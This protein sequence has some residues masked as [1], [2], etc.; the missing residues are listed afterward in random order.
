[1]SEMEEETERKEGKS[2]TGEESKVMVHTEIEA[3]RKEKK[4]T[5]DKGDEMEEAD[6]KTTKKDGSPITGAKG[7]EKTDHKLTETEKDSLKKKRKKIKK[8]CRIIR[9]VRKI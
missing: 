4:L 5:K 9:R 3:I 6:I 1:M 2:K 8:F 7:R